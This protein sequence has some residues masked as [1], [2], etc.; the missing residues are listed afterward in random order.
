M[1]TLLTLEAQNKMRLYTNAVEEEISGIAKAK[2]DPDL[3]AFVI[4]DVKI[5]EQEVSSATATLEGEDIAKFAFEMTKKGESLEEWCVWWHS[6]ASMDV[7]WSGTDTGTMDVNPFGAPFM[8]SIVTNHKGEYRSRFDV[9]SPVHLYKD[10]LEV[11][12]YVPEDD[13]LL[14]EIQ[15]EVKEKVSKKVYV[16]PKTKTVYSSTKPI[17]DEYN[18]EF[19]DAIA[20]DL[21]AR[22]NLIIE[23]LFMFENQTPAEI[24]TYLELQQAQDINNYLRANDFVPDFEASQIIELKVKMREVIKILTPDANE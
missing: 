20:A 4:T 7:F 1:R 10:E 23:Q 21:A 16:A 5:F 12:I 3:D 13:T 19:D 8:L 15:A 11:N 24:V 18:Y 17:N 6:H 2:Y 9:Y 14:K 22:E